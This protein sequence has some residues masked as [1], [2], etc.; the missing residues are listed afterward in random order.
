M[1]LAELLHLCLVSKKTG[2]IT[3]SHPTA[4]G[5]IYLDNGAIIDAESSDRSGVQAF[6]ALATIPDADASLEENQHA[7]VKVIAERSEYLLMEE[8]G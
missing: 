8:F 2:I 6:Y 5:K 4:T 7:R 3:V 1:K